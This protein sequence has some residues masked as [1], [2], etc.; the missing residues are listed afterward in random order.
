[1]YTIRDPEIL[2]CNVHSADFASA[3][4]F[5]IRR[6]PPPEDRDFVRIKFK[7]GTNDNFQTHHVFGHKADIPVTEFIYRLEVGSS[8]TVLFA[9]DSLTLPLPHRTTPSLP[10]S[11]GLLHAALATTTH[12]SKSALRRVL[13]RPSSPPALPFSLSVSLLLPS[14]SSV[15]APR[16]NTSTLVTTK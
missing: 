15:R 9:L 7:N 10:R 1:M 4:A 13:R 12:T 8:I 6:G 5:E 16:S 14:T 3:L 11:S 2:K